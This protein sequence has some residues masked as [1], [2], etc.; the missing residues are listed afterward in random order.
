[1]LG[2][3]LS[4]S[5]RASLTGRFPAMLLPIADSFDRREHA[6]AGDWTTLDILLCNHRRGA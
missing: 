2:E 1:M 5:V 4:S 3:A 6:K